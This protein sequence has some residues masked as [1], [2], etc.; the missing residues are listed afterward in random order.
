MGQQHDKNNKAL[1]NAT[2]EVIL[3]N[4]RC[5]RKYYTEETKDV[6]KSCKSKKGRKYNRQ[7]IMTLVTLF[8]SF[9]YPVYVFWLPCLCLLVTL[10]MSFGYPVYVFWL[11]CLCLLVTLFMSFGYPVY[12]F[13]LPCLCLLVTLFMSFGYPVYVFWLP[14]LCPLVTLFMSF[15]FHAPKHL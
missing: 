8:M 13:W 12:V 11:P 3:H 1:I 10:F 2:R 14:C 7:K 5:S 6:I 15:G 4:F 9:G